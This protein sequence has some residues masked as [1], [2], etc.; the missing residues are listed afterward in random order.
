MPDFPHDDDV[1][2]ALEEHVRRIFST[3]TVDVLPPPP[4]PINTVNPHFRVLRVTPKARR[5]LWLYISNGGWAATENLPQ[6]LEFVIVTPF[7]TPTAVDLL[8]MTV[9]YND[10]GR[11]ALG[12]TVSVGMP[13]LPGSQCN[14]LLLSRP[15]PLGPDFQASD[16]GDRHV[17]YLWL[18]PITEAERNFKVEHGIEALE[19]RF[20]SV[21]LRYGDVK[22]SSVV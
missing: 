10:G 1:C 18:L 14:Y 15:Y 3:G 8:T 7:A 12:Q 13:W 19:E 22:R 2:G 17:D 21:G 6:G 5:G 16:I 20:D 4:G 9:F 11:L